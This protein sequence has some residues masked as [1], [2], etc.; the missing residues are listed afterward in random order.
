MSNTRPQQVVFID[1]NIPDIGDLLSGLASDVKA[2]V[3]DP[4]EDGLAQ[5]T[6]ILAANGLTNL[7][8]ISIVGHGSSGS[9][10]VRC[11]D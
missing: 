7:S 10:V 9:V 3:L 2:F 6:H 1:A 8:S 5:I 4:N 11:G